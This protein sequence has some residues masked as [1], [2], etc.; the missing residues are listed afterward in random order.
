MLLEL[1][2]LC[3][4]YRYGFKIDVPSGR[5]ERRPQTYSARQ[6]LCFH[7]TVF[8]LLVPWA[9]ASAA[10]VCSARQSRDGVL[11]AWPQVSTVPTL[12]IGIDVYIII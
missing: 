3:C 4:V 12:S 5:N 8:R 7:H 2:S 6:A 1:H 10:P 11:R 9:M